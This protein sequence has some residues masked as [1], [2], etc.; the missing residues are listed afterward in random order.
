M[1][2]ISAVRIEAPPSAAAA[3]PPMT[4]APIITAD[5]SQ[6]GHRPCTMAVPARL[7]A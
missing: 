5:Q 6:V 2:M 3:R 7:I 4:E 1:E